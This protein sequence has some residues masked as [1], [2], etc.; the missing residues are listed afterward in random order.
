MFVSCI[1]FLESQVSPPCTGKYQKTV[2][3]QW[4][5]LV[6]SLDVDLWSQKSLVF[7]APG[8]AC[9]EMTEES[10]GMLCFESIQLW[11]TAIALEQQ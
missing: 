1:D 8:S 6:V 4:N 10:V 3:V 5:L 2:G 9:K 7:S 11:V